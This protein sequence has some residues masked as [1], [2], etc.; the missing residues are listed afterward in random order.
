MT[1]TLVREEQA[2]NQTF[3]LR[4]PILSDTFVTNFAVDLLD[5]NG[6][7]VSGE[8]LM[9]RFD[10]GN[11]YARVVTMV[12]DLDGRV[13]F[14]VEHPVNPRSVTLSAGQETITAIRPAP[15]ARLT[16]EM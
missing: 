16:I 14:A 2:G 15:G 8:P 7:E 13:R 5:G 4:H 10:L 9:A 12:S 1:T 11:G 3:G 6:L